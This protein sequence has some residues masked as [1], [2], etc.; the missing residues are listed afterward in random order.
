MS[1][2][3]FPDSES[4]AKGIRAMDDGESSHELPEFEI[5]NEIGRGGMGIV[6]KA[7]QRTTGKTVAIKTIRN[8]NRLSSEQVLRFRERLTKEVEA[9]ARLDGDEFATLITVSEHE[10]QP[11]I[12]MQYIEG[13]GF[14][15]YVKKQKPSCRKIVELMECALRAV[16]KAHSVGVFHRDLSPTNIHIRAKD[17]KPVIL[18]FGVAF[19]AEDQDF[20]RL[21]TPGAVFGS[22]YYMAPE[23]A[24]GSVNPSQQMDVHALGAVLFEM[25]SDKYPRPK[26]PDVEENER[27][28]LSRIPNTS[29][30]RLRE[31]KSDVSQDL[32][33]ICAMALENEPAKRYASV[34]DFADDL[35]CWLAGDVVKANP[36]AQSRGGYWLRRKLHVYRRWVIV[37]SVTVA[38]LLAFLLHI[39][40]VAKTERH[41]RFAAD[42][43]VHEARDSS[44][45]AQKKEA[46]VKENEA[47]RE[48]DLADMLLV[49][50]DHGGVPEAVA[51][52][53]R[54]LRIW[55]EFWQASDRLLSLLEH[56]SW[57]LPVGKTM[58]HGRG[59]RTLAFSPDG[60][61]LLSAGSDG[62]RLWDLRT[63]AQVGEVWKS[64]DHP[65]GPTSVTFSHDGRRVLAVYPR[66]RDEQFAHAR[67]WDSSGKT[68]GEKLT[69]YSETATTYGG[70]GEMFGVFSPDDSLFAVSDGSKVASVFQTA[71]EKLL[72]I[73]PLNGQV[74]GLAFALDG[75]ALFIADAQNNVTICDPRTNPLVTKAS[76]IR[77]RDRDREDGVSPV[78]ITAG[79]DGAM[80]F[81]NSAG[82]ALRWECKQWLTEAPKLGLTAMWNT[83]WFRRPQILRDGARVLI[84]EGP[85]RLHVHKYPG[86]M[87]CGLPI[88]SQRQ[89]VASC[90]SAE[91][92]WVAK[93]T[94]LGDIQVHSLKQAS[95]LPKAVWSDGQYSSD[96]SKPSYSYTSSSA[97]TFGGD[98]YGYDD[99]DE[100]PSAPLRFMPLGKDGTH[101][102][103]TT[104]VSSGTLVEDYL[105]DTLPDGDTGWADA[106]GER[107]G[108]TFRHSGTVSFLSTS[109]K[110]FVFTA[111]EAGNVC[112]WKLPECRVV[113]EIHGGQGRQARSLRF[114]GAKHEYIL[115]E[116][117]VEGKAERELRIA[118][119]ING[120]FIGAPIALNGEV[121]DVCDL[122]RGRCA[123]AS[124]SGEIRL[125][126]TK[127]E[128]QIG[129]PLVR[130]GKLALI[131]L[132]PAGDQ[133][134]IAN[135]EGIVRIWDPNND[136]KTA[137]FEFWNDDLREQ[138]KEKGTQD[139]A[140]ICA[141]IASDGRSFA[142]CS[143]TAGSSMIRIWNLQ[144]PETIGKTIWSDF[145]VRGLTFTSDG[146]FLLIRFADCAWL[147]DIAAGQQNGPIL[148][149]VTTAAGIAFS[150]DQRMAVFDGTSLRIWDVKTNRQ[151]SEP[152]DIPFYET[153]TA[154]PDSVSF[155]PTEKII[156][157]ANREGHSGTVT[158]P[159]GYGKTPE[160]FT[161]FAERVAGVKMNES[162]AIEA[163]FDLPEDILPKRPGSPAQTNIYLNFAERFLLK[164][165]A[166]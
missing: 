19:I 154:N 79:S 120:K 134:I 153:Q 40:S 96:A 108:T 166:Q 36:K 135:R 124:V 122:G 29:A 147:W 165:Q 156:T 56:R 69:V 52:L 117:V 24:T 28:Y 130:F 159:H 12:V 111:D 21:T 105:I 106:K 54:A 30:R 114:L 162:G 138:A 144:T 99:S 37:G 126:E 97:Y 100:A 145:E 38:V 125:I 53:A 118:Y 78:T 32:D 90:V 91:D 33:F 62:C 87:G 39:A 136:E 14:D 98:D 143:A 5:G 65:L 34:A 112:A 164:S 86:G 158:V 20:L 94:V 11:C 103:V 109:D 1:I 140:P 35:H 137:T 119:G 104:S 22:P 76:S 13:V 31:V 89:I 116:Y 148:Y 59:L 127:T 80:Y 139:A 81:L 51:H 71:G 163:V 9:Q 66:D 63:R 149:G 121:Q 50:G 133:L 43:A 16:V 150:S 7:T 113:T 107:V 151:V 160:W 15:A 23:Q 45:T 95:A 27:Q 57:H 129:K 17:G 110:S 41:L 77:I 64:P 74:S 92:E 2:E 88:F 60:S 6:Y 55:P 48:F 82:T 4:I 132:L 47:R 67:L 26:K 18:D 123:V 146:K 101:T 73:I 8:I 46:A 3:P 75:S 152:I 142:V 25:V 141:E 85:F 72:Q 161:R 131:N 68:V 70:R 44:L 10:G 155:D 84:Q 58:K 102:T 115:V 83:G 49:Q 157:A 128:K 42:A 61:F 93:G